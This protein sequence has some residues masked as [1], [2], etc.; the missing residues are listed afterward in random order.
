ML[1]CTGQIQVIMFCILNKLA[2][3]LDK[4]GLVRMITQCLLKYSLVARN[5]LVYKGIYFY[6]KVFTYVYWY[7]CS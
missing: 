1:V 6:I 2:L 5:I 3:H 7:I 4:S